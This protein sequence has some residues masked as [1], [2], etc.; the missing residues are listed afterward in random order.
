[1]ESISPIWLVGVAGVLAAVPIFLGL[2]TSYLKVSIVMGMTRSAL[3]T[4]QVPSGLVVMG[5]SIAITMFLMT[6]VIEQC[7]NKLPSVS[8]LELKNS[9]SL[10]KVK[11]VMNAFE[12]WREFLFKH[13]GKRELQLLKNLAGGESQEV[14][15]VSYLELE[16]VSLRILIPAFVLT[17]LKEAFT[18]AFI[19]LLPFLAVDL[20]VANILVGLGMYMVSPI[21]ISLPLKLILFVVSDGWMLLMRGLIQSYG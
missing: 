4:Q 3:G 1:M 15:N 18:M 20:I 14:E 5:L 19:L 16:K 8:I 12:P 7:V 6:P 9:G 13:S 21:M 2:G 11:E 17:E 10:N